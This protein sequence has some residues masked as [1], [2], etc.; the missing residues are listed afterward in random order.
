MADIVVP[1]TGIQVFLDI[2]WDDSTLDTAAVHLFTNSVS[3]DY[4]TSL[5]DLTELTDGWYSPVTTAHWTSPL[6]TGDSDHW[7][8]SPDPVL[9]TNTSG[10][11]STPVYGAYV[12]DTTY[13]DLLFLAVF[14]DAPVTISAGNTFTINIVFT[15]ASEF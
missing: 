4:G 11:D 7:Q 2:I 14:D 1:S 9:F 13:T 6:P 5:V 3:P 8:T 15:A 10:S 12:T